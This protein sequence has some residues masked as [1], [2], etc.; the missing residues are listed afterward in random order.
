MD[1]MSQKL[2][3]IRQALDLKQKEMAN[4]LGV[5]L[6]A[7]Q[8]WEYGDREVPLYIIKKLIRDFRVNPEWLFLDRGEMF[9]SEEYERWQDEVLEKSKE[10]RPV[11]YRYIPIVGYVSA[12]IPR[13]ENEERLGWMMVEIT[14]PAEKALIVD[15]DSMEPT[16]PRGSLVAIKSVSLFELRSGDIVVAR[17]NTE[18]ALKRVYFEKRKVILRSDSPKY[19]DIVINPISS[20]L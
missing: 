19:E 18:Y 6:R 11:D 10:L 15:G 12:G 7:Y 4:K 8:H 5:S 3:E 16:I 20:N 2:K 1:N 14:S 17:I 13:E 9:L